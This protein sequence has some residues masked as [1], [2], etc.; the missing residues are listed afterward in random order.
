MLIDL[1]SGAGLPSS[2]C[3]QGNKDIYKAGNAFNWSVDFS[4]SSRVGCILQLTVLGGLCSSPTGAIYLCT[5][6]ACSHVHFH[7]ML[8]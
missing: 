5:Y 8:F 7:A 3:A 1:H 4:R 6:V 2:L